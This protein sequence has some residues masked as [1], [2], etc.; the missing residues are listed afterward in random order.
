[1][2]TANN[3]QLRDEDIYPDD[4]VLRSILG[5][6]FEIYLDLLELFHKNEMS[7]EWLY[8]HDSKARLCKVQKKKKTIVWI[9]AETDLKLLKSFNIMAG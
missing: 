9:S 5:Q 8:Y 2:E 3:I 6:S 4:K 7:Y 1:M